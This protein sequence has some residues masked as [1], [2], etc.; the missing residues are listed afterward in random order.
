M[1]APSLGQRE[2]DGDRRVSHIA[3]APA[4]YPPD[5]QLWGEWNWSLLVTLVTGHAVTAF[6]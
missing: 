4:H 6:L 2:G 3:D 1:T 5:R